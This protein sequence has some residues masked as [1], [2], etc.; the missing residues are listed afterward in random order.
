MI[1][2][3][4][5]CQSAAPSPE[6]NPDRVTESW[7]GLKAWLEGLMS[8]SFTIVGDIQSLL[9][10]RGFDDLAIGWFLGALGLTP[11][12]ADR[13]M[14]TESGRVVCDRGALL[15]SF[16]PERVGAG[17]DD[18]FAHLGVLMRRICGGVRR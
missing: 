16:Q 14:L 3:R 6:P 5:P 12:R 11:M 4:P 8:G 1:F 10:Q 18:Y 9:K 2:V 13:A 15:M 17:E 7:V